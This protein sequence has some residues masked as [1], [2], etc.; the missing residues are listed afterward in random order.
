MMY[1]SRISLCAA[2]VQEKCRAELSG[3]L[4]GRRP[5]LNAGFNL[6]SV[7]VIVSWR[8]PRLT[9]FLFSARAAARFM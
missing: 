6:W 8:N 7:I 3:H 4:F 2:T 1:A 9:T 5:T